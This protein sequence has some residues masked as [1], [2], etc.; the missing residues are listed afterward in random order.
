MVSSKNR[1]YHRNHGGNLV[2]IADRDAE[3]AAPHECD[4]CHFVLQAPRHVGLR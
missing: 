3:T 2:E 1:N 4:Q